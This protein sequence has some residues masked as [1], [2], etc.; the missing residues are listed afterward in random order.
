MSY[1]NMVL[2]REQIKL[3]HFQTKV[4]SIHKAT[5]KFLETYDALF[6]TFWET[7][8]S[9]K[10]RIL[11]EENSTIT[12]RNT[13]TYEELEPFLNQV[14]TDLSGVKEAALATARDSILEAIAQ[15]KYLISFN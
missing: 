12:L 15:F 1:L 7:S 14:E 3:L 9:N 13:R 4:Y 2:L 5:D 8:Q 11:L 10:Y 6:D